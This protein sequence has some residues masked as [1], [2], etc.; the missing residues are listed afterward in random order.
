VKARRLFV[1]GALGVSALGGITAACTAGDN[2]V[3]ATQGNLP[4]DGGEDVDLSDRTVNP[5]DVVEPDVQQPAIA[6]GTHASCTGAPGAFDEDG[7]CDLAAGYG[8]CFSQSTG[9]GTCVSE[10]EVFLDPPANPTPQCRGSDQIFL[11]CLSDMP[12]SPCCWGKPAGGGLYTR[13][14]ADCKG[15]AHACDPTATVGDAGQIATCEDHS[16][17]IPKT[18]SGQ[19]VGYCMGD[20]PCP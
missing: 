18:C 1:A 13:Y 6:P 11:T 14:A 9:L 19:K 17:C 12:D 15:M 20:S 2:V 5:S 4:G 16:P 8:C 3:Y 10:A 7:G